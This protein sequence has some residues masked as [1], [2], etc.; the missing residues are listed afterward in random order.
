MALRL[1]S[2]KINSTSAPTSAP[3]PT[4]PLAHASQTGGDTQANLTAAGRASRLI[5]GL[6]GRIGRVHYILATFAIGF[7]VMLVGFALILTV[8]ATVLPLA[9]WAVM[10]LLAAALTILYSM[11]RLQDLNQNRWLAFV[12]WVP[13]LNVLLML[14]LFVV[15]GTRGENR[16]G[17]PPAPPSLG[18]QI[19]AAVAVTLV[20][21]Q[22]IWAAMFEQHILNA[23]LLQNSLAIDAADA[24]PIDPP[25]TAAPTQTV[26]AP[27]ADPAPPPTDEHLNTET[28]VITGDQLAGNHTD[29]QPPDQADTATP[30]AD[31]TQPTAEAAAPIS[32]P[33][34]QPPTN[35]APTIEE[36]HFMRPP[37]DVPNTAPQGHDNQNSMSYADFVRTSESPVFSEPARKR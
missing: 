11:A 16:Y 27:T 23:I 33:Q 9:L 30:M 3:P 17:L 34:N 25:P 1:P 21:A 31:T 35:D 15:P 13:V 20:L 10:A 12:L 28:I 37:T 8:G 18:M 36:L 32:A 14:A 29:G 6:G 4:V 2:K 19:A 24:P 26:S 22:G 7:G 5:R